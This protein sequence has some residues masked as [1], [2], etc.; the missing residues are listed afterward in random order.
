MKRTKKEIKL[1]YYSLLPILKK[2][3]DCK[4]YMI[5]G[6]RSNG[7]TYAVL[8]YILKQHIESGYRHQGAILRRQRED[9]VGKRGKTMWD[10]LLPRI[11][12]LTN[13]RYNSIKYVGRQWFLCKYD[14]DGNIE[15]CAQ[16][17]FCYGFAISEGEH[18]KSSSYPFIKTIL[19]DEFIS[20]ASY[21]PDEFVQFMNSLSTI[22]RTKEDVKIFMCGNTVNKYCPY[23]KEMG[24]KHYKDMQKGDIDIYTYANKDLRVAVEWSDAAP[25]TRNSSAYFAFDNPKLAMI[26]SGDW[27]LDIY[28]HAPCKFR[29]ENIKF[30]FFIDWEDNLLEGDLV[31]IPDKKMEFLF[32]HEKTSPIKYP[33]KD[34]IF[35]ASYSAKRNHF[36]NIMKNYNPMVNRLGKMF[37]AERVFYQNNEVGDVIRNYIDF[38]NMS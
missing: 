9:F 30:R 36:R 24:I 15:Y 5:F 4:Y 11:S 25:A 2:G 23:F 10:N 22:I 8:E 37:S 16:D 1:E 12:E 21:L 34:I 14:E 19:F 18:D 38:C 13:F 3:K 7:K 17:P 31:R 27:E 26:T 20:R 33:D 28:P 32:F 35:S 6:Q 29:N